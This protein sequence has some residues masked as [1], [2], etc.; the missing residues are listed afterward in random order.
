M[1]TVF[2]QMDTI[3]GGS[4]GGGVPLDIIATVQLWIIIPCV[5]KKE[6]VIT[7]FYGDNKDLAEK[8]SRNSEMWCILHS[9]VPFCIYFNPHVHD[10]GSLYTNE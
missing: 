9:R 10:N 6:R 5:S 7:D 4:R 3:V 1:A 2:K 8:E